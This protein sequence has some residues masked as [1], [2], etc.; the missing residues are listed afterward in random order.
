METSG[1]ASIA[2][3]RRAKTIEAS[4]LIKLCGITLMIS[5]TTSSMGS[6]LRDEHKS[7]KNPT[8]WTGLAD[9]ERDRILRV[10]V[11]YKE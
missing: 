4:D 2:G 6:S 7:N 5:T 3:L 10:C 9:D 11:A 8:S 1:I